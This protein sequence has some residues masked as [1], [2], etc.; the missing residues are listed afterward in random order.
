MTPD[1]DYDEAGCRDDA[2]YDDDHDVSPRSKRHSKCSECGQTDGHLY[3]CP[4]ETDDE[5]DE[6]CVPA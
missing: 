3:G 2:Y 6:D 1:Y 5:T 4:N